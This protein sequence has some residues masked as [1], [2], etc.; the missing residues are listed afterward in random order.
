MLWVKRGKRGFT[1]IELLVVIAIIMIL[2]AIL[3]PVFARAKRQAQRSSCINNLKQLGLAFHSYI[4]DWDDRF[5][6]V[7]GAGPEI[8][9]VFFDASINYRGQE[10]DWRWYQNLI[11]GYARNQKIF[12]CPAVGVTSI[13]EIPGGEELDFAMNNWDKT[14]PGGDAPPYEYDPVTTYW[15]N[16]FVYNTYTGQREYMGGQPQ[17]S[18]ARV[19]EAPLIWDCPSGYK[20]GNEAQIAHEDAVNVLYADGH[21]KSFMAEPRMAPWLDQHFWEVE[22]SKGWFD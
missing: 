4:N 17:A 20:Q 12:Q 15:Y 5:P 6:L 2:A 14:K 13:W 1:L 16:C 9:R 21:V 18:C 10:A 22:G 3:F 8:D 19:S 7:S 11:I